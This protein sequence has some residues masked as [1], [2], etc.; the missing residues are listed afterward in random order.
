MT[1]DQKK[2]LHP[3]V[4]KALDLAHEGFEPVE[5]DDYAIEQLEDM[6]KGYYGKQGL[7]DAILELIRLSVE[8]GENGCKSASMKILLVVTSAEDALRKLKNIT[9]HERVKVS[10]PDSKEAQK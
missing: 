2:Q 5:F 3:I 1:E 9:I 7:P 4:K 8:L 10:E 6:L